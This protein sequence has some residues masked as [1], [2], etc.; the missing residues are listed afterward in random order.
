M[1]NTQL[2]VSYENPFHPDSLLLIKQ[3]SIEISERYNDPEEGSGAFLPE[4]VLIPRAAF[5]VARLNE[6]QQA[7]VQLNHLILFIMEI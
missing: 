1:D 6:N 7:V 2:I 5:V 4:D 3:L